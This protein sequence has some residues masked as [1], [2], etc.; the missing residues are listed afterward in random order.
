[1]ISMASYNKFNNNILR[2]TLIVTLTN[3]AT[4]IFAGLVIFSAIATW[5]TYTTCLS[6][7]SLQTG[8]AWCL[9]F[10]QRPLLPCRCLPCGRPSFSS[11]CS[12]LG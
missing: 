5:P 10:I 3:S 4:S 6:T 2:D 7:T 8:P 11:C 9:L 12:A 1:M